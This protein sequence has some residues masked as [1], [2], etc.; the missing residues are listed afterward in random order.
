MYHIFFIHS[1]I[2]EHLSCFHFLA[3]I[4]SAAVNT[5]GHV[6]FQIMVFSMYT[7]KSGTAGSY[8]S[9]MFSFLRKLHRV[10]HSDC[11]NLDSHQQCKNVL[12]FST[13][14]PAFIVCR[15]FEDSHSDWYEV[16]TYC[17]FG[18]HFFDNYQC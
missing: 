2:K 15:L 8:G 6:C 14:S 12:F 1:S 17:S 9:S 18:L 3:T 4:N 5:A 13:P 11:T 16:I 10:L 7:S